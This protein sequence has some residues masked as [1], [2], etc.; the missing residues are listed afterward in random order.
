M[1]WRIA[2]EKS[3]L[4]VSSCFTGAL[5]LASAICREGRGAVWSA[6]RASCETK[7]RSC[8]AAV[9]ERDLFPETNA[10]KPRGLRLR[11]GT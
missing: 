1:R 7:L 8:A 10:S 11:I 2:V 3:F 5:P 9:D 4:V 6:C